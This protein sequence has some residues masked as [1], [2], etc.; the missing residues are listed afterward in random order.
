[1]KLRL[2]TKFRKPDTLTL[3]NSTYKMTQMTISG[4][5]NLFLLGDKIKKIVRFHIIRDVFCEHSRGKTTFC[6]ETMPWTAEIV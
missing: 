6:I 5:L 4:L 2:S 1:M 3:A